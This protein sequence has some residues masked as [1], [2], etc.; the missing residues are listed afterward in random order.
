[1]VKLKGK[2]PEWSL[3]KVKIKDLKDFEANARQMTVKQKTDLEES[4][5]KFNLIDKPIVNQDLTIIAGH[6]R[7]NILELKG[8]EEV[9]VWYP[10]RKLNKKEARELNMRH[11]KNTGFWDM[12]KVANL[13]EDAELKEY[14]WTEREIPLRLN[15]YEREFNSV[16]DSDVP[17]P[18]VPRFTEKYNAVIVFSDNEL[19]FNWLKNVLKVQKKK[20]YK[21]SN[22]GECLVITVKEFQR[23][24]E[25]TD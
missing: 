9:E 25:K 19:D 6:M 22:T 20:C 8:F 15:E 13:W 18:I 12:D 24:F 7:K 1:M 14:G 17:M 5:D 10:D 11:N 3:K 21:S 23:I 16:T 4:I 2:A